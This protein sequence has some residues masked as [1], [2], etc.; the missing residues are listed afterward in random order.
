MKNEA[1]KLKTLQKKR[2]GKSPKISDYN[3]SVIYFFVAKMK[4]KGKSLEISFQYINF[5]DELINF[6]T[7]EKNT[8]INLA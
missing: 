6:K 4:K 7:K 1:R 2:K 5:D 8:S 3:F